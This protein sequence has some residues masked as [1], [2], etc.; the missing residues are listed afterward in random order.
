MKAAR[1]ADAMRQACLLGQ[2]IRW[3]RSGPAAGAA[4]PFSYAQLFGTGPAVRTATLKS[5]VQLLEQLSSE[6]GPDVVSQSGLVDGEADR[7]CEPGPAFGRVA[8]KSQDSRQN[9]LP[10]ES[11]LPA[12]ARAYCWSSQQ[13]IAMKKAVP[14]SHAQLLKYPILLVSPSCWNSCSDYSGSSQS[15]CSDEP[16]PHMLEQLFR[17]VRPIW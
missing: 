4:D 2:L 3:I 7:P 6:L 17:C 15:S 9:S 13:L 16:A 10:D 1:A 11:A 14:I 5:W 8:S 12:K